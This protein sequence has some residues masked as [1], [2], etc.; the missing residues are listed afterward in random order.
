MKMFETWSV[1]YGMLMF[2]RCPCT[3]RR[4]SSWARPVYIDDKLNQPWSN[5][6]KLVRGFGEGVHEPF[7]ELQ[8]QVLGMSLGWYTRICRVFPVVAMC[9]WTTLRQSCSRMTSKHGQLLRNLCL[10][11]WWPSGA[12]RGARLLEVL[13]FGHFGHFAKVVS[14]RELLL[15]HCSF[16]RWC[17]SPKRV[18]RRLF[19]TSDVW[20]LTR[21]TDS[22]CPGATE[23]A[24]IYL[25]HTFKV[26]GTL[27]RPPW[28]MQNYLKPGACK[29]MH[30]Y[31]IVMNLASR[32]H[33][34]PARHASFTVCL[35]NFGWEAVSSRSSASSQTPCTGEHCIA[36][37]V[38]DAVKS[39]CLCWVFTSLPSVFS[40][41]SSYF[42]CE[43]HEMQ[44][45]LKWGPPV[46]ETRILLTAFWRAPKKFDLSAVFFESERKRIAQ[47]QSSL[48]WCN[49]SP[50]FFRS[51]SEFHLLYIV[52]C[53]SSS[54]FG[55]SIC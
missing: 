41:S 35:W 40:L 51:F 28:N 27:T 2:M 33:P 53:C 34:H 5:D 12:G 20:D 19:D 6:I 11:T 43:V 29:Y 3:V 22:R 44:N 1:C 26:Y 49:V 38:F 21:N 17:D 14:E 54:W 24:C 9:R 32:F 4:E 23:F 47:T 15:L 39:K 8:N 18:D 48:E 46:G 7:Y 10:I 55:A 31:W 30:M 13:T 52:I 42:D 16:H 25:K 36:L 45:V 50:F 37:H